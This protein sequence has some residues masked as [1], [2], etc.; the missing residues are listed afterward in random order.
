MIPDRE[1]AEELLQQ[2]EARNSGPGGGEN[3]SRIVACCAEKIAKNCADLVPDKAYVL[4]LLHNIG[5]KFG[6]GHLR[7]VFDGYVYML[8]LGYDEVAKVCLTHSFNNQTMKE[9]IGK[10]DTSDVETEQLSDALAAA[11]FDEYDRLIQL[12]DTLAGSEGVLQM[13]ERM[14][15]VR[16]RYG[17]YPKAKWDSNLRLKEHFERKIG[18]DVYRLLECKSVKL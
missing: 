15:D 5:R 16:K 14:E 8:S 3:H 9:Y 6:A 17:S 10:F 4:G 12:C 1:E 13:K 11:V 18:K 7:H 2:A